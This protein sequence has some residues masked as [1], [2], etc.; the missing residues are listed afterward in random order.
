M[1]GIYRN[2]NLMKA[3]CRIVGSSGVGIGFSALPQKILN[4]RPGLAAATV[5]A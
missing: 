5:T 3:Q 4:S 2:G 1:R